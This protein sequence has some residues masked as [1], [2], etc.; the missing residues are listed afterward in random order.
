MAERLSRLGTALRARTFPMLAILAC[1]VL[2][3]SLQPSAASWP[4]PDS[5]RW[6]GATLLILGWL[7]F[8]AF[9]LRGQHRAASPA[10]DSNPDAAQEI[11]VVYAS[12]TGVAEDLARRSVEALR[13]MQTAARLIDIATLGADDVRGLR[14]ALFVV[15]TTG[16]GD[17]P[18]SAMRFVEQVMSRSL[19]LPQLS[20]GLLALGDRDY[21]NFCAFGH[22]LDAWLRR[23]SAKAWF[24]PV[25]VDNLDAGALRHWQHQLSAVAGNSSMPDWSAPQYGDWRLHARELLNPGSQG[26]A[27]YRI[28]LRPGPGERC[29]WQA[30][31]IAEVGPQNP[32][33][34]IEEFL[35]ARALDGALPIPC[36]QTE[37]PLA[38]VLRDRLLLGVD[39]LAGVDAR[40][41]AR[42]LPV[43]AHREYSIASIAA[44][45]QIELLVRCMRS[46]D[47]R[48][49]VASGWLCQHAA[50]GTRI[51]LRVR[52]NSGFHVPVDARP[53][54]LI[55][56]GSGL[57]GLRGLLRQRI[58]Q[59]HHRNWLI[60]G[61]RNR[62]CDYL[63]RDEIEGYLHHG[64]LQKLDLAFSRDQSERIYVQH[65]LIAEAAAVRD[66]VRQGATIYVCGSLRGMAPGVDAALH[67]ILGDAAVADMLRDARYRRDVY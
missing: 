5:A 57:A 40:D 48:V 61:E 1:V 35:R 26:E 64:G 23:C 51:A 4:A 21:R 31:D 22:R 25:E 52:P 38:A 27:L 43:L 44:D 50:L 33:A 56:N 3:L 17:A 37:A 14:R 20:F 28:V 32:D 49:G 2:P 46:R 8:T 15:S 42:L 62:D 53:M 10:V 39:A 58:A 60:F 67:E 19:E 30:G 12:Q 6:V 7:A 54:I 63:L 36:D 13:R 59:G 11:G 66:W 24:D 47:G 65:R 9:T 18:D 34:D 29:D 41:L 16:E 55:G 45:A